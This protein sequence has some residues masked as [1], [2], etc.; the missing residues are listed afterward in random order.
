M[1]F[2]VSSIFRWRDKKLDDE[3]RELSDPIPMAP[4]LGYTP[5]LSMIEI[6]RQQI[7]GEHLR[8]AALQAEAETFE[9]ADDFD[10]EGEDDISSPWEEQFDP[11]DE[12]VRGRLRQDEFE[13]TY[14][15]R[16][17]N[18]RLLRNA[19]GNHTTDQRRSPAPGDRD[20]LPNPV[21]ESL[22]EPVKT[23]PDRSG[24]PD[25]NSDAGSVKN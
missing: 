13:R 4:P 8:I 6:V 22:P 21:D 20:R 5:E 18:E 7:R 17:A 25:R 10:V 19:H 12:A 16:L 24:L 23:S 14:D 1:R 15:E 2:D 11:V 3:G 9:E